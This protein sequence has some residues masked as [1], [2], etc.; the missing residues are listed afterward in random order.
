MAKAG[1]T[2]T[3]LSAD[4]KEHMAAS[5]DLVSEKLSAASTT[6]GEA[7]EAARAKSAEKLS[8]MRD[9]AGTVVRDNA[10]LVGGIGLA[11]GAL[12]AASLPATRLEQET[13]GETSDR[14]RRKAA[15]A[16][17][18]TFGQVKSAAMS[19]ADDIQ[20]E[21]AD[22]IDRLADAATDKLKTVTDEAVTTA[23][24]PT[25]SHR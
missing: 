3:Q 14:L 19:A 13:I 10:L 4:A 1:D 2:A 5:R 9:Q 11:I 25:P 24:E 18:E 23:F 21:V 16:A 7:I 17:E 6:A 22:R 15:D 8:V 20:A 12:L